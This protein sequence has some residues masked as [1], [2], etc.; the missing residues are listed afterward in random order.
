MSENIILNVGGGGN[1][2]ALNFKVVGNPQPALPS[3]NTIWVN[4]DTPIT[5]YEFSATEPVEPIEGLVWISTGTSSPVEFNAL[6]KNGIQVYPLSA[7]QYV[8]G[9]L[10]D[11]T[12]AIYQGGAWNDLFIGKI[13][14]DGVQYLSL[15][16]IINGANAPV[17]ND[18]YISLTW[19][20]KSGTGAVVVY[21]TDKI[22]V[23]GFE[24]LTLEYS[25]LKNTCYRESYAQVGLVSTVSVD[26]NGALVNPVAVASL[27]FR[28]E[29][30]VYTN[31]KF[32]VDINSVTGEYYV[33]F[34]I[35]STNR[36]S[37]ADREYDFRVT[38][39]YLS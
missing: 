22:N 35:G 29:P 19:N 28:D 24:K 8:D 6:K 12:V 17:Y 3:E 25:Y 26:G 23:S 20:T 11:K 7:K 21:T 16:Y 38:D 36:D 13:Y 37:A 18:S 4:T 30:T 31:S 9:A 33:A 32:E 10:V 15:S 34:S 5:G 2:A 39:L 1:G 14:E 27:T